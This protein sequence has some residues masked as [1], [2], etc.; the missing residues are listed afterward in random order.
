MTIWN[1][2][3]DRISALSKV[4][5]TPFVIYFGYVFQILIQKLFNVPIFCVKS[6]FTL[7]KEDI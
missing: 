5:S 2:K 7:N 1:F 6:V 3:L 4:I